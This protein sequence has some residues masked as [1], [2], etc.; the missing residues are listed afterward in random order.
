MDLS[1]DLR[2]AQA[3]HQ[4]AARELADAKTRLDSA[5]RAYDAARRTDE[6]EEL[7]RARSCWALTL[8]EWAD[9][10]I[11][12]ETAKDTLAAERRRTDRDVADH[13]HLPTRGGRP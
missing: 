6:G 2:A 11:A 1:A 13:L 7:T 9:A 4:T 3:A 10:L 5:G 12:R 8:K